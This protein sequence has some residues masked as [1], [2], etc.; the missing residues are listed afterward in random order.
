MKTVNFIKASDLSPLLPIIEE[1]SHL[2]D[3]PFHL[4]L[5]EVAMSLM[6]DAYLTIIGKEEEKIVC[7]LSGNRISKEEFMITQIHS[8]DPELTKVMGDMLDDHILSHK[9]TKC[10]GL[11]K[12]NKPRW[13]ER[14]GFKVVRYLCEKEIKVK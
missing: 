3:T 1:F 14:Y 7:Y 9:M 11:F 10:L 13:L 6:D 5:H 4:H 8:T 2:T 12:Y